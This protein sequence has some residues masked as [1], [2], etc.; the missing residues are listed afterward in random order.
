MLRKCS[1]HFR[2]GLEEYRFITEASNFWSA[3]QQL[4]DCTS[5]DVAIVVL[6]IEWLDHRTESTLSR[7][8]DRTLP[9]G[10]AKDL[11]WYQSVRW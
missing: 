6:S 2:M 9:D 10:E 5:E 8:I 4:R 7:C 3:V 11:E 1:I